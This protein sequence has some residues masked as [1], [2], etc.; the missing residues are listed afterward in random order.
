[1]KNDIKISVIV[2]IYKV[3]KY[4]RR[5]IDSIINQTFKN[6]EIIL[7]NDG[8]P[9]NCPKICEEYKN[10]DNRIV[11]VNQEN[12]GLSAA[13][14]S[15]IRIARGKYLVF[16]DSDDYIEEDMIEYLYEGIVKYDVDIS[17][18]GYVAVYDNGTKE[19]ITVPSQDTIYK[20]EEALN[21]LLLNGYIDVVAW[22]KLYKKELFNN[23]LYPTGKLYEDMLTTYKIISKSNKI[24]LRPKEKYFYCKR[25][26]SIGGNQFSNKTLELLKACD[27]VYDFVVKK[28]K[29]TSILEI[30]R[31]QWYI[32][33]WNKMILSNKF[34]KNLL[35]KI[36]KMIYKN[37]FNIIFSKELNNVRK[38]Q[39][40][41]LFLNKYV[42]KF[43]YKRFIK[44][45]R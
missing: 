41:L 39:L 27:E 18:C 25:N 6:I 9:D 1:M 10:K 22:N 33:V 3:E 16:I 17:C 20:K 28:Y 23:I 37:I 45:N 44:T 14:N 19:K 7:V 15:G 36:R 35:S 13:R 34:D 26:D 11:I 31:I 40:L 38:F 2:P 42:Y 30:A 29:T 21:I 32:V 12:Q 4:L 5:C 24:L 43:C 8:S